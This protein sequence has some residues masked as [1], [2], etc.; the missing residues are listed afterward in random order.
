[1]RLVPMNRFTS[2]TPKQQPYGSATAHTMTASQ[3]KPLP[4]EQERTVKAMTVQQVEAA[5][6]AVLR[7]LAP[8]LRHQMV[9]PLQPISLIYGVMHHKLSAAQPDLQSVRQEAQK[10]NDFAKAAIDECM[11]MGTWLSPEPEV[12]TRIDTGIKECFGLLAT[13][14][15][16]CGFRLTNEVETLPVMVRQD[17]VRTVLSAALLAITDSMTQPAALVIRATTD[18]AGVTLSVH[19]TPSGEGS[20][21]I[22]D[23]GY[24]RLT[25][26]DVQALAA[27]AGITLVQQDRLVT[28]R[29]AVAQPAIA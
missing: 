6:Y 5:R 26:D 7:R 2:V 16:F 1:M 15:H 9:R 12:L 4:D 29:F 25:W 27:A 17:D 18:T 14:L 28:M 21:N 10:I 19:T 11:D 3:I 24:R 8:S 23:D 22:Y 13:M 20:T